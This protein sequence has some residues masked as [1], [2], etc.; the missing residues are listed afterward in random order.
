M[1]PMM[2]EARIVQEQGKLSFQTSNGPYSPKL[3]PSFGNLG[4]NLDK[5]KSKI[6]PRGSHQGKPS[7][8]TNLITPLKQP[9]IHLTASPSPYGANKI[10]YD[11]LERRHQN[12]NSMPS[13]R[14]YEVL[15]EFM[16]TTN[17]SNASG[18]MTLKRV[19]KLINT[20]YNHFIEN[21]E[22]KG[23]Q[24]TSYSLLVHMYNYFHTVYSKKATGDAQFI[25]V[26]AVSQ[27]HQVSKVPRE[28]LQGSLVLPLHWNQRY[29]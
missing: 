6:A 17:P 20:V 15:A 4:Y 2:E 12:Q 21:V 9:I 3:V 8:G 13:A 14:A 27:A 11:R 19:I 18:G 29:P 16:R 28:Q 5:G 10:P 25:E 22:R 7:G 1:V 26:I 23:L 24:S